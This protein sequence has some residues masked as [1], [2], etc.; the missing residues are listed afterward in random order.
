LEAGFSISGTVQ[1][2]NGAPLSRANVNLNMMAG[3]M[4]GMVDQQPVR[5][6]TDGTF[7]IPALPVG[8]QY[9]VYVSASGYGSGQKAISKIQ[10][11]TN[12]IE[13]APFKL[14]TA[15]REIAGQVLDTDGKPL[16]GVYVNT[17]GNNQ[18]NGNMQTDATGHFKFK[19]CEGMITVNAYSQGGGR[20]NY[21]SVQ[22]RGGDEN[23]V[24]KMGVNENQQRRT[25]SS[26]TT[27]L[28]PQP[29][30]LGVLI[31]WPA[32]H[33]TGTI[34]ILSLQMAALL[35]TGGGIFWMT[36]MRKP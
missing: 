14:R 31:A 9:H 3:N 19:V 23:V 16:P 25:A 20:N 13:L 10:S 36:R 5:S 24:V 4:G 11:R 29:W 6:G 18:P 2:A 27:L 28:K 22:A 17:Y 32:S 1:D 8:Q 30:T 12:S 26:R 35:G 33:K 21:G 7:T 15:D 34:I